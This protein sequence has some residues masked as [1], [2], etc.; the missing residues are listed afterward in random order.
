[1][2]LQDI[3]LTYKYLFVN[4]WYKKKGTK[5][6]MKSFELPEQIEPYPKTNWINLPVSCGGTSVPDEGARIFLTG[7]TDDWVPPLGNFCREGTTP[8]PLDSLFLDPFWG[9]ESRNSASG[10]SS[11]D[12]KVEVGTLFDERVGAVLDEGTATVSDDV[13]TGF[14]GTKR[15]GD[16]RWYMIH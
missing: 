12:G 13:S 1:M 10:S 7:A 3:W 4:K 11:R 9:D 8:F 6:H 5:F 2:R 15:D 14:L 16:E